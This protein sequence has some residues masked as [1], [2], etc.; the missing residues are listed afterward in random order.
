MSALFR[1]TVFCLII[2]A[3]VYSADIVAHTYH[4]GAPYQVS[5]SGAIMNAPSQLPERK[6]VRENTAFPIG[7]L[8]IP[9]FAKIDNCSFT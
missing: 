6:R 1:L 5:L 8:F 2:Y 4:L 7:Y 3:S 9:D